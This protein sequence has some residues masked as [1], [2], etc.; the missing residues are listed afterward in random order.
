MRLIYENDIVIQ[1]YQGPM[2]NKRVC[3]VKEW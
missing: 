1:Q 3:K 2:I